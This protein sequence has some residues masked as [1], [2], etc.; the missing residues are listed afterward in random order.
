MI[1][2]AAQD[3]ADAIDLFGEHDSDQAMGPSGT[4]ESKT[5]IGFVQERWCKPIRPTDDETDC[6]P[7]FLVN[8]F[9]VLGKRSAF[10][11]DTT[12]VQHNARCVVG[13]QRPQPIRLFGKPL[14]CCSL[15]PRLDID[16]VDAPRASFYIVGDEIGDWTSAIAADGQ[17]KDTH[18]LVV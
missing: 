15:P 5:E 12:F 17:D 18:G 3:C 6:A 2:M 8:M 11:I 14:V 9:D 7:A 4:A 16:N 1:G 10:Q 13:D